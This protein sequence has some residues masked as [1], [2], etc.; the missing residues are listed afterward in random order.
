M[1]RGTICTAG[2]ERA[3]VHREPQGPE[4]GSEVLAG[5]GGDGGGW[6]VWGGGEDAFVHGDDGEGLLAENLDVALEVAFRLLTAGPGRGRGRFGSRA[7]RVVALLKAERRGFLV[8]QIAEWGESA[9]HGDQGCQAAHEEERPKSVSFSISSRRDAGD[10][11]MVG[12]AR[13]SVELG[14][15]SAQ[16]ADSTHCS[17][18]FDV[19]CAEARY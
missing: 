19:W 5:G 17:R 10:G 14:G 18:E 15:N 6:V 11:R 3:A 4:F 8:R 1:T 16:P 13:R 2:G 7:G 9:E 12:R